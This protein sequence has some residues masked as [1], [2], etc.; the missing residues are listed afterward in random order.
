MKPL[1]SDKGGVRDRIV[2]IENN[3]IIS[4]D[5]EVAETFNKFF[6]STVDS[7]GITENK[8]L[9]NNRTNNSKQGVEKSIEMYE[10]HPSIISIKDHVQVD[11]EFSFSSVTTED[12]KSEI[13][14]LNP[15]KKG[16]SIP[17]KQLKEVSDIVS[18][19]I[20]AIWNT[21]VIKNKTFPAELKLA[22]ITPI[23][24]SLQN[25][26][27]KNYRPIS[28]LP[29]VSKILEKIMDKQTTAYIEQYLS[30]YLCGYRKGYSC[31]YALLSMIEN[32]K[33][34]RDKGGHA[35]GILMDLSKAFDTINHK[36]LV[37][38]L[39][40][41]GFS[42]DALDIVYHYLS[43][44]WQRTKINTA[45]STWSEIL[46]GVP[47]GS[48]PGPKYFNIYIND[49]FYLFVNTNVCNIADD[50][51]PYA[52]D[53]DLPTLL[54]NLESDAA[55]AVM[56]FD[57][58][59]MKLNQSKCHFIIAS[60]SSEHMWINVG[61]QII[62]ESNQEKLLG[63]TID[64]NIKFDKHL[65]NI[66]KKASAKVTALSRLV[67]IVPL[68]KKKILMNSFITSQFS[69]CPLIWMFCYS[70][71]LNKR[72]NHI[73]ERGLRMVY[74]DYTS[75]FGDL[76]I[77]D[78]SVCIHHRNIQLVAVE[79]FKVKHG[80]CP[81]ILKYLFQ[82]NTNPEV[83]KTF[84]IP[85]V[86]NEYMGKLSLRWFGPVV[87]EIMLPESYKH[88]TTLETFKEDIKKW[89]PDNCRCR[90]CKNYVGQVGFIETFE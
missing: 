53:V 76:L 49:L 29:I 80:L 87:W 23:F 12:I 86:N 66:C 19:H 44:R 30:P 71:K 14:A 33:M 6:A 8:L 77:K 72:I 51:T 39:H 89:V 64:K 65:T 69:Y 54:H 25:S 27:K 4:E 82:F 47:Q 68:E 60:H 15:K 43:D 26:L 75:S 9:L 81:K 1:F 88:I 46:C 35:G 37:A 67:K 31:Q 36:L 50:T 74:Q 61:G 57:A 84:L 85:N 18:E 79:M 78:G 16:G 11:S 20:A 3:D 52:C 13:N 17:T 40:A 56:W 42:R 55:S 2:L 70:R 10:T 48:V 28:V 90:L 21:E 5:I 45:F 83:E 73:H 58:N 38:K 41:Y 24:K 7:L 22:D 32:W 62:W 59:Y 63:S 34:S